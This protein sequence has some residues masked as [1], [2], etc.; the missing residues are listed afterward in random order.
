MLTIWYSLQEAKRCWSALSLTTP[1]AHMWPRWHG[2]WLSQY[3]SEFAYCASEECHLYPD[4]CYG[5]SG[6]YLKTKN[7]FHRK[8]M[9]TRLHTHYSEVAYT[10][11]TKQQNAYWRPSYSVEAR[12]LSCGIRW[13][14]LNQQWVLNGG[15]LLTA[16]KR[17]PSY[18][19]TLPW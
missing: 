19:L 18:Y 3:L 6:N 16:R 5:I 4:I 17:G 15:V 10:T 1:T 11:I 9:A 2:N 12:V 13:N 7:S 14:V 8:N